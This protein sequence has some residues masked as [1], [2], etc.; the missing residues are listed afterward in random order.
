[1]LAPFLVEPHTG[2]P[3]V[4]FGTIVAIVLLGAFV[5]LLFGRETVGLLE[6]VTEPS[7]EPRAE[8][9]PATLG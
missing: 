3:A 9:I 4:F 5:P 6:H 2:S 1:M 8:P 7:V